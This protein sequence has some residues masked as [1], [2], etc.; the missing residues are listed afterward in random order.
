[1]QF[2]VSKFHFI[3]KIQWDST[4]KFRFLGTIY[5]NRKTTENDLVTVKITIFSRILCSSTDVGQRVTMTRD[6][7]VDALYNE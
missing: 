1:M 3:E 4:M 7:T 5:S 6:G 2:G